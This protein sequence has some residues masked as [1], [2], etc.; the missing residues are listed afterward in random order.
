MGSAKTTV[1]K[2][3][4][5][6]LEMNF[7][8]SDHAIEKSE[9]KTIQK[10]FH[11]FGENYFRNLEYDFLKSSNFKNSIISTGGGMPCFGENMKML[12]EMGSTIYL[13]TEPFELARRLELSK[14]D[15]PLL[16]TLK[17]NELVKYIEQKLKER[18]FYYEQAKIQLDT[19]RFSP[20]E[21]VEKIIKMIN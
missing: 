4:Y 16:K 6:K 11:E 1:G 18:N 3:L 14:K 9:G 17:G 13:Y 20:N 7:I 8:D 2:L 12:N 19:T 10:I 15:R 21:I 5:Q